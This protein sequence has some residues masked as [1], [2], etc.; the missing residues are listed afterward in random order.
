MNHLITYGDLKFERSKKR[1]SIE[2]ENTGWFSSIVSYGPEDLDDK[3]KLKFEEILNK[4]RIGGY[5]IWRPYIIKKKLE[6]INYNDILIYLDSGCKINP[7]GKKRLDEYIE[8]LNKSDEGIISFQ[9]GHAEKRYTTKEIFDYF[10]VNMRDK[11]ANSGQILSGILIMKK[12]T[13]LIKLIDKW[14]GVVHDNPLLFTDHYNSNQAPPFRDN[15]HEQSVFSLIRK[16]SNPILVRDETY[17]RP[18]GNE[19]SLTYPFWA[20][21]IRK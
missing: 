3:F 1:L 9:L 10:D 7:S 19:V 8:L 18:F 16:L 17:F 14:L 12:N 11:I 15:R 13:N 20:T 2:A 4:P 6:E 21:R 5:G